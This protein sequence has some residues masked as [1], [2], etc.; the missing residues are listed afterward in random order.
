LNMEIVSE[1][2]RFVYASDENVLRD[3]LMKMGTDLED[4]E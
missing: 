4:I 3:A 1:A 2:T